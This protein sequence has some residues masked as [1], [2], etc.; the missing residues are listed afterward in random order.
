MTS[1]TSLNPIYPLLGT[2]FTS[3]EESDTLEKKGEKFH[4]PVERDYICTL[5]R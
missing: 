1:V 4:L 2:I 3:R 5:T